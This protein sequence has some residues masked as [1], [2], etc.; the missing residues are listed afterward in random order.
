MQESAEI[1]AGANVVKG[2]IVYEAVAQAFGL[3]YVPVDGLI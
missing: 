2:R 3:E 1:K